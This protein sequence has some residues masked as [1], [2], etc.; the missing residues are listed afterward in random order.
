MIC[1]GINLDNWIIDGVGDEKE[2][3]QRINRATVLVFVDLQLEEH[4]RLAKA[5]E[6]SPTETAPIGC[7]YEGMYSRVEKIIK[8]IDKEWIPKLRIEL[9]EIA[10]KKGAL[11]YQIKSLTEKEQVQEKLPSLLG[12][13]EYALMVLSKLSPKVKSHGVIPTKTIINGPKNGVAFYIS[14]L[15]SFYLTVISH[16]KLKR[17]RF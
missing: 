12:F 11:F 6:K 14:T 1:N 5:R 17:A 15:N 9:Q 2:F 16:H 7:S 3:Y 4:L 10:R 8:R 13:V